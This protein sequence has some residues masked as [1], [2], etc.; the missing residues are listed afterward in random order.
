MKGGRREGAGRPRLDC[1]MVT[2]GV[3]VRAEYAEDVK[4]LV[5]QIKNGNYV[6][7]S[8]GVPLVY[9]RGF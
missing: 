3:R 1:E 4:K 9:R 6:L 7:F 2:V 8:D 5:K